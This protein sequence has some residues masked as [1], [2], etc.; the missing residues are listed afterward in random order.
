M[1]C[2]WPGSKTALRVADRVELDPEL[3]RVAGQVIDSAYQPV[4]RRSPN[5]PEVTDS[6][7]SCPCYYETLCQLPFSAQRSACLII[8][9][10]G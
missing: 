4:S 10:S 3:L 5:D 2:R 9:V 6:V 1:D 7:K 8:F